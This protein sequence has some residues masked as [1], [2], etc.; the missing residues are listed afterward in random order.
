MI[1][2]VIP[3][4]NLDEYRKRNLEFV[5][6]RL[7][8]ADIEIIIAI[9]DNKIDKY[10]KKFKKAKLVNFF[11]SKYK[12]KCNK[13]FIFNSCIKS[14]NFNSNFV[15]FLDADVYLPFKELKEKILEEDEII[16]PFFDCFYINDDQTIKFIK[17]KE[18]D[19]SP[20]VKKVYFLGAC[21]LIVKRSVLSRIIFDENFYSWGL[22]DVNLGENAR[23]LKIRTI[24]QPALHLYHKKDVDKKIAHVFSCEKNF[25]KQVIESYVKF[26][27]NRNIQLINCAEENHLSGYDIKFIKC[28]K[29]SQGYYF[30]DL[31]DAGLADIDGDEWIL[32][33]DSGFQL[34]EYVYSDISNCE[35]NYIEIK[36]CFLDDSKMFINSSMFANGFAFKKDFLKSFYCPKIFT[37]SEN[38]ENKISDYFKNVKRYTIEDQLIKIKSKKDNTKIEKFHNSNKVLYFS[39]HAPDTYS[40]GGD[41]LLKILKTLKDLG[42]EVHFFC[43][44]AKG[45]ECL[46]NLNRLDIPYYLPN[47]NSLV[48]FL[49][50]LESEEFKYAI[51]SW[52]DIANQYLSIVKQIFPEIKTIVDTVDVHWK[53]EIRGIEQKEIPSHE[54]ENVLKRKE[55]EKA[56]YSNADVIFTVTIDDKKEIIKELGQN[57]NIKLL[58]NIHEDIKN[59]SR[60][61]NDILFIGNYEHKPNISAAESSVRIYKEFINT[62]IYKNLKVKPKLYIAGNGMPSRIRKM[63]DNQNIISMGRVE[64][65]DNLYE[66]IRVSISPLK[67]GSGIKGKICDAAS[68]GKIILTSDIGNEGIDLIDGISGFI[69]NQEAEFVKKL[70]EIYSNK[71]VDLIAQKGK[72]TVQN[73]VSIDAA[74]SV[75]F[76]TLKAKNITIVIVTYNK[77][78]DL[79][80]CIESI[81]KNTEYPNY[82]IVIYDNNSTD[83]TESMIRQ[84]QENFDALDYIKNNTNDYFVIPNNKIMNYLNYI[85]SDVVLVNND[86]EI[87]TK[88]WLSI[89]YS[90]AY[91]AYDICSVGCKILYPDYTIAEAGAELYE[92]GS[93]RNIGRGSERNFSECCYQ[94]SVGY[95]SGCLLYMRR[96]SINKI[97]VFDEDFAPMYYEESEWQYRAHTFGL[98]TIYEPKVEV[99]HHESKF[100][101]MKKHQ[102]INKDKFVKKY[103]GKNIEQYNR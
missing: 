45:Q 37:K 36:G 53:R 29:Y 48:G 10:Y 84:I 85:N 102:V 61:A 9:Q 17:E 41:R 26:S 91:S 89:L 88:C 31:I 33:T 49:R 30:S 18:V 78:Q 51:F 4:Y 14:I 98:K 86:I 101:E 43:N 80:R 94:R 60:D 96:D 5:F 15:L 66:K 76:H 27:K 92:D 39:P 73:L 72:Q 40:S 58:S 70:S 38:T 74:K 68:R 42:Y 44:L 64:N 3:V 65:L 63:C 1:T 69:A 59:N 82:K 13:S 67:W 97:G 81:I 52:Y 16:Q 32:Y 87:L 93:G 90:T 23:H 103:L 24:I 95:C 12:N 6:E 100:K 21:S 75:L 55:Q 50:R 77:C 47:E 8:E 7:I 54:L 71:S 79:K 2:A 56:I 34:S 28:T 99:I 62:N 46:D 20:E 11:D 83:E 19:V 57:N 22:E 25:N 35:K